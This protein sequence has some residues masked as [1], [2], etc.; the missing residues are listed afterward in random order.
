MN[1][2]EGVIILC[3]RFRFDPDKNKEIHDIYQIATRN[4][5]L[6]K[7]GEVFPSDPTALVL[8][9]NHK[10]DVI[11][12]E[13][14]FP[15]FKPKQLLINARAETVTSKRMFAQPFLT[16]RCVYPTSGFFEWSKNKQ[17]Y[18]FDYGEK[19]QPLYIGGFFNNFDNKSRSILITTSPND[20]VS[21]I[22]NRMPLILR[23]DQIRDWLTNY[24]YA[25]KVINQE[26]PL[27]QRK[28][29]NK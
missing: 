27:L 29:I 8:V 17:K 26:M 24:Q 16:R 4:G 2:P 20:S 3:G 28:L 9:R 6:P 19:P 18:W 14:G 12:M 15:G 22:H 25:S 5:Y 10:I 1:I 13:W 23:K 7:T 11:S 21:P